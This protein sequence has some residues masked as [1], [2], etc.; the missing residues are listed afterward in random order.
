MRNG[1]VKSAVS[2]LL[3]S[4]GCTSTCRAGC[5]DALNRA[6]GEQAI[7]T[8]NLAGQQSNDAAL[9]MQGQSIQCSAP[10]PLPAPPP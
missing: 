5:V 1:L 8:A 2:V 3:L 4:T 10:P 6:V 7:Q 9:L